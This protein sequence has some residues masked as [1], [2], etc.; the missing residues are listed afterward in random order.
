MS[1]FQ[2]N[3]PTAPN[4]AIAS[5]LDSGRYRRGVGEPERS[6]HWLNAMTSQ[7]ILILLVVFNVTG[8]SAAEDSPLSVSLAIPSHA[9][10]RRYLRQQHRPPSHFHAII[11]NNSDKPQKVW[12]ESCSWGYHALSFEVMDEAGKI[13]DAKKRPIDFTVNFPRWHELEPGESLV[14]NVHFAETNWWNGFPQPQRG[15]QTV[16]MRAVFTVSADAESRKHGVWSGR[17]KSAARKVTIYAWNP[18]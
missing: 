6:A 10:G 17:I 3:K 13:T 11:T 9:D 8:G 7:V 12:E 16:T 15:E 5:R 14:V 2:P 4:P 1:E 18:E